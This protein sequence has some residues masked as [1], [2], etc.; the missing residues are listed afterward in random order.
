MKSLFVNA[1]QAKKILECCCY[2]PSSLEE[3]EQRHEVLLLTGAKLSCRKSQEIYCL[4]G[5]S[6]FGDDVDQVMAAIGEKPLKS[7]NPHGA[8]L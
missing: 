1:R 3:V 5:Y 4:K 6:G 2:H 8:R 7:L